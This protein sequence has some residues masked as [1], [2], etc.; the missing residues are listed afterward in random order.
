MGTST[1]NAIGPGAVV[2]LLLGTHLQNEFDP[3]KDKEEYMKLVFTA[4][5][6]FRD[7]SGSTWN[8]QVKFSVCMTCFCCFSLF[9]VHDLLIFR[10]LNF[11][12]N[13]LSQAAIVEM[14]NT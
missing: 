10:R 14:T 5:L 1:E 12:I 7:Y 4:T 13:F 8:L 3:A 6:F 2:S 11:L 9:D